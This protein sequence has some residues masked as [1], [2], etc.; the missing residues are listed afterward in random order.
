MVTFAS[1]VAQ[2]PDTFTRA[3]LRTY[4]N[5]FGNLSFNYLLSIACLYCIARSGDITT[6]RAPSSTKVVIHQLEVAII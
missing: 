3:T 1:L 5:V 2:L 6:N 4:L